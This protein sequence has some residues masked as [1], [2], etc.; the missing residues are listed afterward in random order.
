[1]VVACSSAGVGPCLPQENDSMKAEMEIRADKIEALSEQL[2]VMQEESEQLKLDKS[3]VLGQCDAL[4][5]KVKA[6]KRLE[7]VLK[8]MGS[9]VALKDMT[10]DLAGHL[11]A[12]LASGRESE[13]D[14]LR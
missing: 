4:R 9:F 12:F 14:G 13:G 5:A 6:S 10:K 3:R 1:L 7:E 8:N 2:V 11:G